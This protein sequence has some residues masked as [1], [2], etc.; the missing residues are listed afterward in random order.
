M[1]NDELIHHWRIETN[2]NKQQDEYGMVIKALFDHA[3]LSFSQY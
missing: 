3:D 1:K 2:R